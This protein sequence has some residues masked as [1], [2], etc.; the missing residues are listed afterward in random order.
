MGLEVVVGLLI[1]WAARK[2]GRGA[3]RVDG[4]VDKALDAGLD[5]VEKVVTAKL[6]GDKALEQLQ[7]E[8]A[9]SGDPSDRTRTRVR[10][11]LEE[12]VEANPEFAKELE[13]AVAEEIGRAHV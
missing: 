11:S 6:G 12:A 1:A 2:A 9:E 7:L 8:A 5:R 10:L 13:A 4:M 3:K